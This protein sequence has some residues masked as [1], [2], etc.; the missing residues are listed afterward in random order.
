[1]YRAS[2]AANVLLFVALVG[3][4]IWAFWPNDAAVT[5][6]CTYMNQLAHLNIQWIKNHEKNVSGENLD[7]INTALDIRYKV[8]NN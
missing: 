4:G 3:G 6:D 2:I 8:C 1:M 5:K 7:W